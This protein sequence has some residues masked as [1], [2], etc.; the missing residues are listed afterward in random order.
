MDLGVSMVIHETENSKP[1]DP[2]RDGA[3]LLAGFVIALL[4]SPVGVSGAVFLAPVQLSVLHVPN[5]Q[6]TPTNL[7]YNLVAGPGALVRYARHRAIDWSLVRTMAMGSVPGVA[8]GAYLRVHVA[9]DPT[10]FQ[11]VAASVLLPTGLLL[12]RRRDDDAERPT[13]GPRR[14]TVAAL[15][16]VV[17][18]AGG[19]YGIGGGSLLGPILVVLGARLA[20]VAPAALACTYVTSAIGAA[21]FAVLAIDAP[22]SVAPDVSLG[23]A[24]GLGGLAGGYLGARLQPRLPEGLLRRGLAVAAVALALAYLV[25]GL[26]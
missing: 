13:T 12:L 24:A 1:M 6:L 26:S 9:S 3:A 21:T 19:L 15:A 18:V 14:R 5:P 4:T 10:A 7:L 11:L 17:G 2:V 22:G 25:A 20:T 8:I 23:I 16:L